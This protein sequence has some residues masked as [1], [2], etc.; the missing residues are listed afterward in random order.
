LVVITPIHGSKNRWFITLARDGNITDDVYG[1]GPD[2]DVKR[3]CVE[4]VRPPNAGAAQ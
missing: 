1:S 3:Q 4:S 2:M